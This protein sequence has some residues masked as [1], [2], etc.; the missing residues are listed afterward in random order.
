MGG[1][2]IGEGMEGKVRRE[3]EGERAIIDGRKRDGGTMQGE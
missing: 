3:R 2:D 1:G